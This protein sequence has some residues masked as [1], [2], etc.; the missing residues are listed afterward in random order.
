M[1]QIKPFEVSELTKLR[2]GGISIIETRPKGIGLTRE[3][4]KEDI[5]EHRNYSKGREEAHAQ[6]EEHNCRWIDIGR[7]DID[8]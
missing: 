4:L 3:E 8:H 1:K 2:R 6:K 5:F 7:K